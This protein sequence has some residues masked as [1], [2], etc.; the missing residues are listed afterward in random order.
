MFGGKYVASVRKAFV[1]F[2]SDDRGATSTEWMVSVAV[3]VAMAVPVMA[4]VGGSSEKSTNDI[5]VSIEDADSFGGSGYHGGE[6][7]QRARVASDARDFVP[8]ADMGVGFPLEGEGEEEAV[9]TAQPM[10]NPNGLPRFYAGATG[11]SSRSGG[12]G[13]GTGPI[14]AP[15]L[16]GSAAGVNLTGSG[17][18]RPIYAATPERARHEFAF[19]QDTCTDPTVIASIEARQ[20]YLRDHTD[21]VASGR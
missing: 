15:S 13:S 6:A 16:G 2:G 3:V 1:T 14:V 12:G 9:E 8:G 17:D 19:L 4:L 5:V 10:V 20:D 18:N 7:A 11:S 21:V